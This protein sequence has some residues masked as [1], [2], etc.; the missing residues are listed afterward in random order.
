[1][2]NTDLYSTREKF[3]GMLAMRSA[4]KGLAMR[5]GNP[6]NCSREQ[7]SYRQL[8]DA[9][10]CTVPQ[11]TAYY[12]SRFNTVYFGNKHRDSV[13]LLGARRELTSLSLQHWSFYEVEILFSQRGGN[14]DRHPFKS[15]EM[16]QGQS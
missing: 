7:R 5:A 3:L 10:H 1:M 11:R 8:V 9:I 6:E 2:H 4:P 12:I 14:R 16:T 15:I 13:P